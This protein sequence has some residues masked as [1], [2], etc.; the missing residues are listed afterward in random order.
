V[1]SQ[2]DV[3]A[4]QQTQEARTRE[5]GVETVRVGVNLLDELMNLV[6]ELVLATNQLLQFSNMAEDAGFIP[7]RSA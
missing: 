3:R 6:G 7:F 4:A 1:G 5:S 2:D